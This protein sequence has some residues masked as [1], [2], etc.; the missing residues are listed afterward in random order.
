V[1]GH[2]PFEITAIV[3][4]G[5]A[6][7]R[8]GYALLAPGAFTRIRS[9]RNAADELV[10]LVLGAAVMLFIAAAIEAFWSPSSIPAQLKWA[11]GAVA[12][13]LVSGFLLWPGRAPQRSRT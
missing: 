9:L 8:M 5:G 6:G 10:S 13:L 1:C 2:A 11:F 12:T 7:L 3:I 4:A